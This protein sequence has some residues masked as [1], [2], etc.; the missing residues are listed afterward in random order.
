M[1][2]S[3]RQQWVLDLLGELHSRFLHYI[4]YATLVQKVRKA[5]I[6]RRQAQPAE[7]Q[8]LA[9]IGAI[10]R[11]SPLVKLFKITSLVRFLRAEGQ[12]QAAVAKLLQVSSLPLLEHTSSDPAPGGNAQPYSLQHC[13]AM[14]LQLLFEPMLCVK[15]ASLR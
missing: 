15:L 4:P 3:H 11:Q 12:H 5:R 6:R 9:D 13:N 10:K 14:S 2:Q 8:A 7:L 1:W